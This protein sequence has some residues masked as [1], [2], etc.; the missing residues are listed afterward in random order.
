MFP[1][2]YA[3]VPCKSLN[4]HWN[5][6][7]IM[8]NVPFDN[9]LPLQERKILLSMWKA[10]AI[11]GRAISIRDLRA[12][13]DE[14]GK[15]DYRDNLENLENKLLIEVLHNDKEDAVSM[16]PLGLAYFRQIQDD[17]LKLLAGE[18]GKGHL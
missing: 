6:Y 10:K 9:D 15:G 4:A 18:R 11:G 1:F 8:Q 7:K 2:E 12:R 14:E 13:L 5:R 17:D 16:T 3:R